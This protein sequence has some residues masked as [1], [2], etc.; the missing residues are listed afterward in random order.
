ML[1]PGLSWIQNSNAWFPYDR[2]GRRDRYRCSDRCDDLF[3][4]DR[5]DSCENMLKA[6]REVKSWRQIQS[7]I[8]VAVNRRLL[9]ESSYFLVISIIR[10]SYIKRLS[11][12]GSEIHFLKHAML[13]FAE[14]VLQTIRFLLFFHEQHVF[15]GHQMVVCKVLWDIFL[16]LRSWRL[17]DRVFIW[18][19]STATF[20][21]IADIE[22]FH[23]SDCSGRSRYDRCGVGPRCFHMIAAIVEH[24]FRRSQWSYGKQA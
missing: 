17:L 23:P 5:C 9:L 14:L 15:R 18:K 11:D 21:T 7:T 1:T 2:H 22:N 4:F 10:R 12:F 3:P 13:L 24:V 8:M 16:S 20:V 6:W 19:T